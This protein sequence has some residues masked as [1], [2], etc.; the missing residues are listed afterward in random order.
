MF[1]GQFLF[2]PDFCCP[3]LFLDRLFDAK[4]EGNPQ[5]Y[6]AVQHI[7]VGTSKPAPYLVFG[8]PGT[9]TTLSRILVLFLVLLVLIG[10]TLFCHRLCRKNRDNGGGN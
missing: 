2:L 7:V 9:G 3:V 1:L 4:M 6:Q 8:P 5:Q 10:V